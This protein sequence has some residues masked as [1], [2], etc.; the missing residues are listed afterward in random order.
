[1][2]VIAEEHLGVNKENV[3]G[4]AAEYKYKDGG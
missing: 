4:T 3:I 2:R 1:M